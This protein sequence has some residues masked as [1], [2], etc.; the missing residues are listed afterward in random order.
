MLPLFKH[1]GDHSTELDLKDPQSPVGSWNVKDNPGG[2][3]SCFYTL[4]GAIILSCFLP[5]PSFSSLSEGFL[6][7]RWIV[8]VT[9]TT[10]S[11]VNFSKLQSQKN[12]TDERWGSNSSPFLF[13]SLSS[14]TFYLV[15]CHINPNFLMTVLTY[16]MKLCQA[17]WAIERVGRTGT[18]S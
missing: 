8:S 17:I 3:S 12:P 10:V 15:Y 14:K 7:S 16:L 5:D 11:P 9:Q 2:T 6:L 13:S 1:S 18:I 4:R